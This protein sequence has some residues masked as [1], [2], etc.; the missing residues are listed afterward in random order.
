[1]SLLSEAMTTCHMIDKV[2]TTDSYGGYNE[3][4]KEGAEFK[5]AIRFDSSLQARV[6]EKD[7]VTSLYTITTNKSITLEYHNII[8]RDSDGKIFRITSDGDDSFTPE[9]AS[10]NMRQVTAEEFQL[11]GQISSNS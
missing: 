10:L 4:Y 5:A 11:N 6:A 7:G 1:M 9:S 3:S 2:T 8:R